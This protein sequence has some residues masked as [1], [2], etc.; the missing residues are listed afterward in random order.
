MFAPLKPP[1]FC[2]K[3]ELISQSLVVISYFSFKYSNCIRERCIPVIDVVV[4][5]CLAGVFEAQKIS[6]M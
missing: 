1:T 5:F 4:S 3:Q 2:V 6:I